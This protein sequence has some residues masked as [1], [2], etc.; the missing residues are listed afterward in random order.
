MQE[1]PNLGNNPY[2]S[3]GPSSQENASP[4]GN[5]SGQNYA[6]TNYAN[7]P[8]GGTPN[9]AGPNYVNQPYGGTP[10]NPAGPGYGGPASPNYGNQ[11]YGYGTPGQPVSQTNGLALAALIVGIISVVL[12]WIPFFN[13][14]PA[15]IGIILGIL[16]RRRP[17]QRGLGLAG[18]ILS[19][20]ALVISV[21]Y[22]IILVA[23][24]IGAANSQ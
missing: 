20:I 19:I 4:Y 5:P 12:C 11:P 14:V 13:F 16:A 7:Q 2:N 22:L 6:D 8:Y 9:N 10:N 23:A 17:E 15:I 24:V 18:L 1:P 3:Y 21:V